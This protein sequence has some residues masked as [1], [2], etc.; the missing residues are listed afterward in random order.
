MLLEHLQVRFAAALLEPAAAPE[1]ATAI[2]AHV[3][4]W[5]QLYRSHVQ[6]AW[7]KALAN[8]FPVVRALVGAEFFAVLAREYA[9]MH[10]SGDGDLNR[11]GA[12]FADL[13]ATL[14]HTRAL[15]YLGDVAALEWSV[16]CAY[17]AADMAPLPRE[18]AAAMLPQELLASRFEV[19]PAAAWIESDFPIAT[20]WRAHLPES[21]VLLP[22][23]LDR[24][25]CAL[26]ARPGW[27]VVVVESSA[28]ETAAL[29]AL[30][31]G[32]TMDDAI[33]IALGLDPQFDFA[34]TFVRWLDLDL[35]APA[36]VL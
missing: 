4:Q 29:A 36:P 8:S 2:G 14:E 7:E 34:R 33:G 15:P 31:S 6:A 13:I 5:R 10:P 16:Q 20:I 25:E 28:A 24:H 18:R 26:V 21:H 27:Q 30:R 17:Y 23:T 12:H 9:R 3:P 1:L 19:H 11:F 35:L 32:G 22:E